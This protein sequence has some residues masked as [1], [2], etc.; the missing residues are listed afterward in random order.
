LTDEEKAVT[1]AYLVLAHAVLEETIE[2]AFER[3]FQRLVSWFDSRT[4][5]LESARLLF[6]M[7]EW[8]PESYVPSFKKRDLVGIV[9]AAHK[10]FLAEVRGNHGIK[11][12]NIENLARLVGLDWN[13]FEAAL[14]TQMED[15]R[16]LGTKRGDAGH[17]SPYSEKAV[18]LSR[19]DYPENVREWVNAGRDAV[20]GVIAHLHLIVSEQ[21]PMSLIADWDGN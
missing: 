4:L 18:A 17:L 19:Q 2:A 3:H 15:L 11:P 10:P 6:A 20:L 9:R 14:N 16:T 5:P 1:N 7:R 12:H 21:Q 13:R 8:M